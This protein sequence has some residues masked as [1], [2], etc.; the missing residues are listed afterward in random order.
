MVKI[1]NM[2]ETNYLDLMIEKIAEHFAKNM[3]YIAHFALELD[4]ERAVEMITAEI[5]KAIRESTD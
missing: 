3:K 4:D 5:N 2:E 1:G